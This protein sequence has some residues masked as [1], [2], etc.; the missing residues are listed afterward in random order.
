MHNS[1]SPVALSYNYYN[2][3]GITYAPINILP[4][5]GM[6]WNGVVVVNE[7]HYQ[8]LGIFIK[9]VY[10]FAGILTEK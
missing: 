9:I 7:Y 4:G 6:Q 5:V 8:C 1:A 2:A 10:T 3:T